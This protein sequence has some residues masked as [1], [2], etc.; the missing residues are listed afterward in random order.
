MGSNVDPEK[1]GKPES[2]SQAGEGTPPLVGAFDLLTQ[3]RIGEAI[4]LRDDRPPQAR[5]QPS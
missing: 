1:T 5:E 3:L 4:N 2:Q